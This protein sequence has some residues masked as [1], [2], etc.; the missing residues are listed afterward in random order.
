[1]MPPHRSRGFARRL[2]ALIRGIPALE[3]DGHRRTR[4]RVRLEDLLRGFLPPLTRQRQNEEV[5]TQD[6]IPALQRVLPGFRDAHLKW[7]IRKGLG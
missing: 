3:P 1:M 2:E 5:D 6:T 4:N 7:P